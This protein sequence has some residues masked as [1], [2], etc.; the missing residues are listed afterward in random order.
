MSFLVSVIERRPA[1][2]LAVFLAVHA[3]VW[4]LLP[5]LLYPNLP[6]DLIEAL[7]Y[8]REWQLGYDK[9]PPLPWWMVEAAYRAVGHDVAY[10]GLAQGA[11]VAALVTVWATARPVVGPVGAFCTVLIVDGLHY[12][13]YTAAKFNHDVIQLPF[14]ALAG[15]AF[16]RA[17]RE[18]RMW[19][20]V[21]LGAALGIA[22][23]AKYFVIVLALPLAA[24][25]LIDR[26]A[27]WTLRGPGPWVAGIVALAI[28]G[29]H[30]V[31]LVK[32]DFLP[33]A[34]AAARARPAQGLLDHLINPLK[35]LASQFGFLVPALLIAVPLAFDRSPAAEDE[36]RYDRRI[37][38]LLAFGPAVTVTILSLI[39]GRATVAMW[40]YPLWL[41][42]GFWLVLRLQVPKPAMLSR[43]M[44]TWAAIIV[45]YAL[46]FIAN[47]AVLPSYD[48]R[49]R[50]TLFPGAALAQTVSAGFREATGTPLA[51]V[52]ADMW[53]GGNVGHYAPER[54]RVLIDGRP[55]RTP[56]I[57][58]ADLAR[59][60][61]VLL[62]TQGDPRQ[63]PDGLAAFAAGAKVMEPITL[64]MHRDGGTITAGW[65]ILPP[66]S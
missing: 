63:I 60:G 30:L 34:Y 41:F 17:L 28:A 24:F 8:G 27:R 44:T 43:M 1:T 10:Y 14:W 5:T 50:A 53:T 61:A 19:H 55:E 21:V 15:Y 51:Y 11:V 26:K 42:V 58:T 22:L 6:L 31:W 62:W 2:A 56:W 3:A 13:N 20:W 52:V 45:V 18:G 32:N 39:S 35:F 54:P 33:F 16:H 64:P 49:Y 59:R 29:P 12:L 25:L 23:W 7:T 65:A 9:L 57:A 38:A 66:R 40:G 4:T 37:A 46:A 47:Y 48:Q 36:S